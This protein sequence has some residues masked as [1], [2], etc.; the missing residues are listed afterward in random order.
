MKIWWDI[1][2]L[3]EADEEVETPTK[4]TASARRAKWLRSFVPKQKPE[5]DREASG[6][7]TQF[8]GMLR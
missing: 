1:G 5:E 8:G 6:K 7:V 4:G 3:L 2:Q